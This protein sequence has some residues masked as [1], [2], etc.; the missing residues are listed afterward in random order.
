MEAYNKYL[1][2]GIL[3]GTFMLAFLSGC[4]VPSTNANSNSQNISPTPSYA[5]PSWAAN[6]PGYIYFQTPTSVYIN[7]NSAKGG[8]TTFTILYKNTMNQPVQVQYQL[9]TDVG[10][11][12]YGSQQGSLISGTLNINGATYNTQ[13]IPQEGY[14][15]PFTLEIPAGFS[16][17]GDVNIVL[18]YTLPN[19]Q[20]DL[21]IPFLI[22][23]PPEGEGVISEN[24]PIYFTASPIIPSNYASVNIS[25]GGL[26]NIA[27]SISDEEGCSLTTLEN[28]NIFTINVSALDLILLTGRGQS[29]NLL[30]N[31]NNIGECSG[32]NGNQIEFVPGGPTSTTI[33]CSINL[34]GLN[35]P[36]SGISAY[37][38]MNMTYTCNGLTQIP[39]N[40][41]I[42]Q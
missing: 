19:V 13:L 31:S 17:L 34:Q 16:T 30:S 33:I 22:Q 26:I 6:Q 32:I 12:S 1:K 2:Y 5:A 10:S 24:V 14:L 15:G 18:N 41:Q 25:N 29:Y 21:V 20:T 39:V 35:L 23:N 9:S 4:N 7:Y 8:S 11:L 42:I 27:F 3:F 36:P 37:L 38:E 28:Y 40:V